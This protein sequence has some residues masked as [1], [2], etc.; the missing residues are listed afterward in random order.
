[1]SSSSVI[2]CPSAL[3]DGNSNRAHQSSEKYAGKSF[4][5]CFEILPNEIIAEGSCGTIIRK[6]Q[7]RQTQRQYAVKCI[8][9]KTA[10]EKRRKEVHREIEILK[11]V[12]HS[13][14]LNATCSF[15]TR[16]EVFIVTD[17]M[18]EGDCF[19]R[20]IAKEKFSMKETQRF[21][22]CIGEA[23]SYLH[24]QDIVHRDLKLENVLI[25][26][27]GDFVLCDFGFARK[28]NGGCRTDCGTRNS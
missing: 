13:G 27:E 19:D 22:R 6:A 23:L 1:M 11:Q 17:Y 2:S 14:I 21:I 26:N 20:L 18:K 7:E 28:V 8:K 16:E 5:D 25:N 24:H 10:E 4:K 3:D 9:L 15:E 12:H